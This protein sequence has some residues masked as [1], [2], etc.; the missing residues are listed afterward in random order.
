MVARFIGSVASA[1]SSLTVLSTL[2]DLSNFLATELRARSAASSADPLLMSIPIPT[3]KRFVSFTLVLVGTPVCACLT[4]ISL[5]VLCKGRHQASRKATT[6][7]NTYQECRGSCLKT[8][9]T[10]MI[11]SD[12]SRSTL[13]VSSEHLW[14]TPEVPDGPIPSIISAVIRKGTRSGIGR[15]LPWKNCSAINE[16][17]GVTKTCLI[18]GDP[19]VNVNN[20]SG[21][22][23]EQ[24]V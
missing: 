5:A 7:W 24:D 22:I 18:K 11:S 2:R 19:Q 6:G 3:L 20:F 9:R 15:S 8:S 4:F 1:I 16:Q 12:S 21:N 10:V 14:K 23:I 17:L 13:R